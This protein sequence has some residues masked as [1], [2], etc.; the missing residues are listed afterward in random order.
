MNTSISSRKKRVDELIQLSDRVYDTIDHDDRAQHILSLGIHA[1]AQTLE[2]TFGFRAGGDAAHSM[3]VSGLHNG[4]L[5]LNDPVY[6][7]FRAY[8]KITRDLPLAALNSLDPQLDNFSKQ[9]GKVERKTVT[10]TGEAEPNARHAVHL[11]ALALPY[12]ATYYSDLDQSK[13]A[14]YTLIHDGPERY[15]GD[16]PT[17]GISEEALREK[18]KQEAYALE[19]F[20]QEFHAIYPK[21]V[22]V[23]DQYEH[24]LDDEARFVKTFDKLDPHFVHLYTHGTILLDHYGLHGEQQFIH[25]MD[26]ESARIRQYGLEFHT[27]TDDRLE[28]IKRSVDL[29]WPYDTGK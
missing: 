24:R 8:K 22:Q 10:H 25:D 9:Y 21:L 7:N 15:V 28:F 27:V 14:L 20:R 23:V 26:K 13:I 5:T 17:L 18:E 29:T 12:A 1:A 3:L 16:V 2:R 6:D 19:L 4:R 11:A